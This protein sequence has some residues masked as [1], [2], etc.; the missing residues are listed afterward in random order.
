MRHLELS[1]RGPTTGDWS[2]VIGILPPLRAQDYL[3]SGALLQG[4][5]GAPLGNSPCSAS[6]PSLQREDSHP[7]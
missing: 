2:L 5:S 7:T 4:Q 3:S 6:S 1:F